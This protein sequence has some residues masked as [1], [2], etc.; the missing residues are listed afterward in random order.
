MGVLAEGSEF[1]GYQ[2]RGVV[3][4]GAMGTVYRAFDPSLEREIALKVIDEKLARDQSFRHRFLQEARAAAR[5]DHSS[6][7]TVHQVGEFEGTPYIAMRLVR[8][9][10]LATYLGANGPL[11]VEK[12]VALL[13]PVAAG[14]D[15]AHAAGI[16][17]R[18]VKPANILVPD[19]GSDPVLVD[20]GIGRVMQATRATQTGSWVG[21]VD[22]V[23]PEQIQGGDVDG[24]VDQYALACVLFEAVEGSPPF[25]RP[26]AIQ[27]L[28]A[29]ASEAAPELSRS[30]DSRATDALAKALSKQPE[31]RFESC[32]EMVAAVAG[33]GRTGT[34]IGTKGM[35]ATGPTGT[36]IAEAPAAGPEGDPR[37]VQP[38]GVGKRRTLLVIGI[39]VVLLLAVG[40]G[41]LVNTFS[42]ADSASTMSD[43]DV[44]TQT[45]ETAQDPAAAEAAAAACDYADQRVRDLIERAQGAA[46][47]EQGFNPVVETATDARNQITACIELRPDAPLAPEAIDAIDGLSAALRASEVGRVPAR[48][49]TRRCPDYP[50]LGLP[51]DLFALCQQQNWQGQVVIL[52]GGG[53]T[54]AAK[55]S[56]REAIADLQ[57]IAG[58]Q[59]FLSSP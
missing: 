5:I 59:R 1:A 45:Q 18:D 17:H 8:G 22:Y 53:L 48:R 14:L 24:R 42:G 33:T 47:Q 6:I 15:A 39:A 31:G 52:V 16:V 51:A 11:A 32:R 58:D 2:I 3:G 55:S 34:V 10:D 29:H 23:A 46:Y 37:S 4:E 56:L 12:A 28:F 50:D 49:E 7:V 13:R 35:S 44:S 19:D 20:F 25:S 9:P 21:T 43:G 36:M 40:I 26:D 41:L 57:R 38:A 54:G 27:T 30:Q